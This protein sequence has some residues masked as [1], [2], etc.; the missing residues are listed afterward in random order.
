MRLSVVPGTLEGG[1]NVSAYRG[2]SSST[3]VT[4]DDVMQQLKLTDVVLQQLRHLSGV[5]DSRL[6]QIQ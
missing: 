2:S 5:I 4:L 1:Q 6:G 3:A